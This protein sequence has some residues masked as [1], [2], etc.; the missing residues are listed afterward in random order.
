MCLMG[1]WI[2]TE[3]YIIVLSLKGHRVLLRII[4]SV[5]G[6]DFP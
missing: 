2:T 1:D 3:I 6:S 4:Y 5:V